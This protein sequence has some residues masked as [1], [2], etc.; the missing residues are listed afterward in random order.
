VLELVE[1]NFLGCLLKRVFV[2]L[3][4]DAECFCDFG[5]YRISGG[6][7]FTFVVVG[8]GYRSG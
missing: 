8:Q 2:R 4:A 5:G 3:L 7:P 1:S 6:F